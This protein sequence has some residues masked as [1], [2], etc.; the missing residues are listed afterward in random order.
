MGLNCSGALTWGI[1]PINILGNVF[2]ICDNLKKTFYC[3]NTV[4][5]TYNRKYVNQLFMLT[6]RLLVSRLLVVMFLGSQKLCVDFQL[7]GGQ[8]P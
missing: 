4:Y 6:V 8:H 3:N 5:N 1:F 7:C 2:E